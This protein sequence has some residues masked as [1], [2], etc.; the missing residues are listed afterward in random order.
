MSTSR[1][2]KL[3]AKKPA[4]NSETSPSRCSVRARCSLDPAAAA[5]R[6]H[7]RERLQSRTVRCRLEQRLRARKHRQQVHDVMLGVNV[8]LDVLARERI[9]HRVLEELAQ[10]P[11]VDRTQPDGFIGHWTAS[12]PGRTSAHTKCCK[13]HAEAGGAALSA[14]HAVC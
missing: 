10:V 12:I 8:D 11:H 14:A 4:T 9:V 2:A 5:S 3:C 7:Q 6:E 13:E 1:R